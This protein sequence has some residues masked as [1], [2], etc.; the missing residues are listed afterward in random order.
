MKF[1][2]WQ[3][4]L[5]RGVALGLAALGIGYVIGTFFGLPII[6]WNY[7]PVAFKLEESKRNFFIVILLITTILWGYVASWIVSKIGD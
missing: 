6:G 1:E 4:Y 2:S 3:T 7:L 5:K